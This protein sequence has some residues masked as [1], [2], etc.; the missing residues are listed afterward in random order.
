MSE[1]LWVRDAIRRGQNPD[2]V[3]CKPHGYV[4]CAPCL[5]RLDAHKKPHT[6]PRRKAS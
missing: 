2:P 3:Q 4:F 6:R 1:C 5:D